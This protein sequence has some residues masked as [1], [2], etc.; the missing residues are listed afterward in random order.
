[1]EELRK[2]EYVAAE[3]DLQQARDEF[4][5]SALPFQ[6]LTKRQKSEPLNPQ[7][8]EQYGL[9]YEAANRSRKLQEEGW[10]IAGDIL[11]QGKAQQERAMKASEDKYESTKVAYEKSRDELIKLVEQLKT[12]ARGR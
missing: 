4:A 1:I 12:K 3:R 11:K 7:L 9:I 8:S 2:K 10:S 6:D 5:R